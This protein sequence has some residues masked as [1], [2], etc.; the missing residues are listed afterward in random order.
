LYLTN[1]RTKI[2][3]PVHFL[4]Q[5]MQSK[6]IN[7]ILR[8]IE[9]SLAQGIFL[10]CDFDIQLKAFSNSG[11]ASYAITHCLKPNIEFLLPLHEKFNGS[12]F[13]YKIF[14]SIFNK[15]PTCYPTIKLPDTLLQNRN[16]YSFSVLAFFVCS[17]LV[18][19]QCLPSSLNECLGLLLSSAHHG[20]SIIR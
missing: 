15:V 6:V 3:F 10:S 13:F 17:S 8:Y 16:G 9:N 1:T 11:W 12:L 19:V 4:S 14:K 5:F 2:N 18:R 7:P 20:N